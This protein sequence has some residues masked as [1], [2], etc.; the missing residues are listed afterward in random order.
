MAREN[1]MQN[2]GHYEAL[3][4]QFVMTSRYANQLVAEGQYAEALAKH[5]EAGEMV[6]V[7][8]RNDSSDHRYLSIRANNW[9]NQGIDLIR[10]K[11]WREA[12]AMLT[13]AEDSVEQ[14]LKRWPDDADSWNLMVTALA[15][16]SRTLRQLGDSENA[17]QACRKAFEAVNKALALNKE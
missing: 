6:D 14:V 9:T 16:R 15:H 8:G 5:Q 10:L 17:R 12:S 1:A 4:L 2:P 7:L 13:K 3:D 11:R